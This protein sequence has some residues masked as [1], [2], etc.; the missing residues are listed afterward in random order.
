[1]FRK[2]L[3]FVAAPAFLSL[4]TAGALQ[5]RP[6]AIHPMAPAGLQELWHWVISGPEVLT[7]EGGAMDPNGSSNSNKFHGPNPGRSPRGTVTRPG[8]AAA[9]GR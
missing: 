6:L 1:M 5:A 8:R 3:F 4:L 2:L 9:K 7:K